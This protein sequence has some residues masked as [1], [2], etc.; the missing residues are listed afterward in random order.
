YF[1]ATMPNPHKPHQ[2]TSATATRTLKRPALDAQQPAALDARP[3]NGSSCTV[4]AARAAGATCLRVSPAVATG[5]ALAAVIMMTG[6]SACQNTA[7]KVLTHMSQKTAISQGNL[8][9]REDIARL[10][11]GMSKEEV[12]F[13]LGAPMITGSFEEDRW[14]YL[15]YLSLNPLPGAEALGREITFSGEEGAREWEKYWQ[16]E[17]IIKQYGK[18]PLTSTDS[19]PPPDPQNNAEANGAEV[20][21]TEASA[22]T[23]DGVG[24]SD[25]EADG[26]GVSTAT[27]DGVGA[28]DAETGGADQAA[29]DS[30]SVSENDAG[31]AQAAADQAA[32]DQAAADDENERITTV[33]RD[34]FVESKKGYLAGRKVVFYGRMSL[35]FSNS[36][37]KTIGV[38]ETPEISPQAN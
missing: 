16:S 38:I 4:D 5:L 10:R 36:R 32:A 34:R 13:V 18:N 7:K 15:F 9:F 26:V 21:G 25:A 8:M 30:G 37:L 28:V 17:E 29:T 2:L 12:Q 20:D 27:A 24:A 11:L 3:F 14:Y 23:A 31:S 6:L 22:A 35:D 1:P 33:H 19:S